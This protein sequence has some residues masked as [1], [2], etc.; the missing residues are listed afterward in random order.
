MCARN[1]LGV[2]MAAVLTMVL[3]APGA[4]AFSESGKALARSAAPCQALAL[5]RGSR[6]AILDSC[7]AAREEA[8]GGSGHVRMKFAGSDVDLN[9]L[10]FASLFAAGPR[11]YAEGSAPSQEPSTEEG[12]SID[13]NG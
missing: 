7:E 8:V 10:A 13:I 9:G 6:A 4:G 12:P 11:I 5:C 2:G 1:V 3:A